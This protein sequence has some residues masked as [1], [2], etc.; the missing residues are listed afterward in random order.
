[1]L[2]TSGEVRSV[3]RSFHAGWVTGVAYAPDGRTVLSCSVD[4]TTRL[5]ELL[6]FR[7]PRPPRSMGKAISIAVSRDGKYAATG[8]EDKTV[9][10]WN[11]AT[12]HARLPHSRAVRRMSPQ[13]FSS[14]RIKSRVEPLHGVRPTN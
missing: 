14:V 7:K 4:K 9:K 6:S 5:F 12:G 11:L 3:A 1:M 2:A 13:L 10:V 8:S